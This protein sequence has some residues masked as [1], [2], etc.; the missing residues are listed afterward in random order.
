[1]LF[2]SFHNTGLSP[3][4]VVELPRKT[5]RGLATAGFGSFRSLGSKDRLLATDLPL[6]RAV[7][8]LAK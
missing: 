2:R 7:E 3:D 8:L 4:V 5:E 6:A 1:M